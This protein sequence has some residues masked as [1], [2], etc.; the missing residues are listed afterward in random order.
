MAGNGLVQAYAA[1]ELIFLWLLLAAIAILTFLGV[2]IEPLAA[3]AAYLLIPASGV[4]AVMTI[5]LLAEPDVPPLLWPIAIP[6]LIPPLIIGYC[7]ALP[8]LGGKSARL[9]ALV[10]WGAVV[11]ISSVPIG[12]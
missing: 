7:V 4:V 9:G 8:H 12:R 3:L 1:M 2:G 10:L 11:A 6:A 5:G